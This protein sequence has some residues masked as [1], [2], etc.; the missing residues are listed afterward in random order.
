MGV[1]II[2][3][4]P[5][6]RGWS[7]SPEYGKTIICCTG[8]KDA[9]FRVTEFDGTTYTNVTHLQKGTL[10]RTPLSGGS[11]V[12]LD[13]AL[14]L[15]GGCYGTRPGNGSQAGYSCSGTASND[16]YRYDPA[17]YTWT[18]LAPVGAVRPSPT[19]ASFPM[20]AADSRRHR[21]VYYDPGNHELWQ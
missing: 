6:A 2:L 5:G 8:A 12:S 16:L 4:M 15:F 14:W 9:G 17:S 20:L 21:L 18:K 7:S 11:L 13:G 19:Y 3:D 1:S 10:P